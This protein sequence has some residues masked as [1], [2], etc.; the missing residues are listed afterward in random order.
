MK[1]AIVLLGSLALHALAFAML[2][3]GSVPRAEGVSTPRAELAPELVEV[4]PSP[5]PPAPPGPECP[6]VPPA[7]T[8]TRWLAT[9]RATSSIATRPAE[10]SAPAPAPLEPHS[11]DLPFP[12]TAVAETG[13]WITGLGLSDGAGAALLD[14][15]GGGGRGRGSARPPGLGEIE[16]PC[17]WPASAAL[18][19]IDHAIVH[20]TV[21]VSLD[22]R[23]SAPELVDDPGFGFGAAAL[24]CSI[25][26]VY[27][28][29]RSANGKP[30]PGRTLPFQVHFDRVRA[31]AARAP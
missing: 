17:P 31:L 30:V 6:S 5:P 7:P 26:H 16:W 28:S 9:T 20:M 24:H 29:G 14:S 10:S 13:D 21:L 2:A 3:G 12:L 25:E 19:G 15:L 22:G 11:R 18:A 4:A 27:R 23:P 1:P 8:S